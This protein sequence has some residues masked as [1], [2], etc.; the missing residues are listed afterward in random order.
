MSRKR[1]I[2]GQDARGRPLAR[3]ED[4][5]PDPGYAHMQ[6]VFNGA[7]ERRQAP[8]EEEPIVTEAVTQPSDLTNGST[9]IPYPEDQV[10][11]GPATLEALD[12][13]ATP[14]STGQLLDALALAASE[15]ANAAVWLEEAQS[16]LRQAEDYWTSARVRLRAAWRASGEALP[17]A[18]TRVP[19]EAEV[20]HER[21]LETT[22]IRAPFDQPPATI[23]TLYLEGVRALG[24]DPFDDVVENAE[25][26]QAESDA[27][28]AER[29]KSVEAYLKEDPDP[30]APYPEER[31]VGDVTE[32]IATAMTRSRPAP[33]AGGG[34]GLTVF[35]QQVVDATLRTRGDRV[36]VAKELHVLRE[37]VEGTLERVGKKGL[38]PAELIPLLPARFAKYQGA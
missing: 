25:Q 34:P 13:P 21:L 10:D 31:I 30:E 7:I 29:A 23:E 9:N 24:G 17:P 26:I 27:A 2:Y 14:A 15:A 20:R 19:S 22:L 18:D 37:S 6:P 16:A 32:A 12:P 4:V 5:E 28:W 35:Q 36:A 8:P 1:V 11:A 3:W 33:E 38:L